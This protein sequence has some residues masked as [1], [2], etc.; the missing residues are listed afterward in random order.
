[1]W[2]EVSASWECRRRGCKSNNNER[3][4][5]VG[6][7]FSNW[8][9][10]NWW[11]HII[12]DVIDARGGDGDEWRLTGRVHGC[13]VGHIFAYWATYRQLLVCSPFWTTFPNGLLQPLRN[14]ERHAFGVL[15]YFSHHVGCFSSKISG[16]PGLSSV[17]GRLAPQ[18]RSC[19]WGEWQWQ[20][21]KVR[22]R[23]NKHIIYIPN[24]ILN[25]ML[26]LILT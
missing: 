16:N 7:A 3:T 15:C 10:N 4:R 18:Y 1:M 20:T 12:D 19:W 9:I 13:H 21:K 2:K 5:C 8:T 22:I 17:S 24:Q 26:T 23:V 11:R 14:I 6:V 25:L